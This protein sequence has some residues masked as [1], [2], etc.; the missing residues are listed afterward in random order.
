MGTEITHPAADLATQMEY[1]KL[2]AQSDLVPKDYQGQPANV[3]LAVSLGAN[4]GLS[5]A[6]SLLRVHVIEGRPTA[7]AELIAD[8]VRRAGHLLRIQGDATTGITASIWRKDDPEFEYRV[9]WT[10]ER[11]KDLTQGRNGIKENWRKFPD[12]MLR[13]RA[14][15]EVARMACSDALYGVTYTPDEIKDSATPTRPAAAGLA[16]IRQATTMASPDPAPP[17]DDAQTLDPPAEMITGQQV[18]KMATLMG[19]LDISDRAL[20]LAVVTEITGRPIESRNELTKT[21]A[22]AV[23]E[24]LDQ[25]GDRLDVVINKA[26]LKL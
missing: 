11:A 14:I 6:E 23:I 26:V 24:I 16:A 3:L 20:A 22:H 19:E 8:N 10:M 25:G 5:P 13:A 7:S 4:M 17:A 9:T 21:E 15:S 18:K 2:L 1:A 12:A